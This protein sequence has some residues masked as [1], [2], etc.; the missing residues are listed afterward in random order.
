[1]RQNEVERS[2]WAGVLDAVEPRRRGRVQAL[3][4]AGLLEEPALIGRRALEAYE[5]EAVDAAGGK[6][7]AHGGCA[8]GSDVV[9]VFGNASSESSRG[10]PDVDLVASLTDDS[11]DNACVGAVDPVCDSEKAGG[12]W[13]LNGGSTKAVLTREAAL[14]AWK[15][16]WVP[17]GQRLASELKSSFASGANGGA[18]VALASPDLG[19]GTLG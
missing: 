8:L 1:M 9:E 13:V 3:D 17:V 11:V 12:G 18:C 15:E 10:L 4:P 2:G 7:E 16:A 14:S 5:A 19:D 6:V